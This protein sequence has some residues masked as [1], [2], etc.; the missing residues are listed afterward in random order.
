MRWYLL[1]E[2][3]MNHR[4]SHRTAVIIFA[5]A[6]AVVVVLAF[7]TTLHDVDTRVADS[8]TPPGTV[9]LAKPH[10]PLD[11]APGQANPVIAAGSC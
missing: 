5:V 9:G 1:Q 11:V 3:L 6:L 8:A 2:V 10:K 7:A 4:R